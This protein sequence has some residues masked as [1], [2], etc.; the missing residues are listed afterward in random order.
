[1]Y[2][3]VDVGGTNLKAARIAPD[4]TIVDRRREPVAGGAAEALFA[5]LERLVR[6]LDAGGVNAVGLGLPGIIDRNGRVRNAPNL[7]ILDGHFVGQ[8]MRRRTGKTTFVEND[9]NAAA[10]AEAWLGAGGGGVKNLLFVT[11]GTGVGGGLVLDGRIWSGHSGYA[12]EIGH[13]QVEEGGLP[14]GCGSRGCVETIAGAAGWTRLAEARLAEARLASGRSS[15]LAG[16]SLDPKT[17][18]AAA[19]AGDPVARE[20]V[21]EVARAL[22]IGIA[23][24]LLLINVERVAIGGGVARAGSVLLDPIVRQ[25]RKRLFADLFADSSIGPA[26]MGDDAGI[27]GAARVAMVGAQVPVAT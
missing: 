25:A 1:M 17:I 16:H 5:Q 7:P 12:G 18:S 14:C 2:I 21:E 27:I 15:V 24:V 19:G 6:E 22:G 10:L 3:G 13:I 8:E 9:A 23:A 20:V 26:S 4:G 11:L